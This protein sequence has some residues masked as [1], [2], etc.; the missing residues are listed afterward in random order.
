MSGEKKLKLCLLV[1]VDGLLVA[2]SQK[3]K[4]TLKYVKLLE[5]LDEFFD[6]PWGRESFLWTLSTLK[7]Q[8]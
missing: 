8:A 1:I 2:T 6:F 7:P 4:P 5:N 3:P